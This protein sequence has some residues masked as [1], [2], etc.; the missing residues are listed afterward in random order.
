MPFIGR[1]PFLAKILL[2]FFIIIT[3]AVGLGLFFS[4]R[5]IDQSFENFVQRQASDL[6]RFVVQAMTRYFSF[7]GSWDFPEEAL[8]GPLRDAPVVVADHEGVIVLS[9]DQSQIG[10]QALPEDLSAGTAIVVNERQVGTLLPI[11]LPRG[12]SPIEQ[13]FLRSVNVALLLAGLVVGVI[14]L[15]LGFG[16]LR[17]FTGPL[18]E[19]NTAAR[20]IAQGNLAQRVNVR[21][22][23]E[24][25]RLAASFNEMAD[26]LEQG[27]ASK[28]NMI[29]D[30]YHELRTPISVVQSGLESFMDNVMETKPE[31]IAAMHGQILLISRLVNDLQELTLADTGQLSIKMSECDLSQ[32]IKRIQT[33]IG[34]ELEDLDINFSVELDP[35][36]PAVNADAH[37]VEQVLLNLLSNSTRYTNSGGSIKISAKANDDASVRVSVCDSGKGLSEEE[38][39]HV[40]ERFYRADKSRARSTGGSGLGLSIARAIVEAHGGVIWAEN[41]SEGGASFHFLLKSA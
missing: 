8:R 32:I 19:M 17:H 21:N 38:L 24:L 34:A 7:S 4:S 37:R 14:A 25:G 23:D 27:E 22:T 3:L 9:R 2:S 35:D 33:A 29:A 16:L 26:S 30:I 39:K 1:M 31:N 15:L 5:A 36:L 28:R 18:R 40:F 13:Q 20:E 6:E 11:V 41:N 10:R 12:R